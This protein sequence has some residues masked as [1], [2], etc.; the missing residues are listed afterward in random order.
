MDVVRDVV[1]QSEI[2][3]ISGTTVS[4]EIVSRYRASQVL[5][6]LTEVYI[7]ITHKPRDARSYSVLRTRSFAPRKSAYKGL[8]VEDAALLIDGVAAGNRQSL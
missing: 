5:I 6:L 4:K 7:D 8:L 3:S 1:V 2:T